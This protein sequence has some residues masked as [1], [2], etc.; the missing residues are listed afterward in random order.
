MPFR[1]GIISSGEDY[2]GETAALNRRLRKTKGARVPHLY[3]FE[4]EEHLF[5]VESEVTRADET[6]NRILAA[7]QKYTAFWGAVKR[8]EFHGSHDQCIPTNRRDWTCGLC[9]CG[10]G[11]SMTCRCDEGKKM[12]SPNRIVFVNSHIAWQSRNLIYEIGTGN[13]VPKAKPEIAPDWRVLDW[14]I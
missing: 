8:A 5:H 10:K 2:V 13:F 4:S 11:M 6:D 1:K 7:R 12:L 14:T 9:R 3:D